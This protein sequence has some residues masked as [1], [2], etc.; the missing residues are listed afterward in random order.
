MPASVNRDSPELNE[1][2]K[3]GGQRAQLVVG[4]VQSVEVGQ[5]ADVRRYALQRVVV[6]VELGEVG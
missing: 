6:Q 4:H 2:A 3:L 5:L 1:V